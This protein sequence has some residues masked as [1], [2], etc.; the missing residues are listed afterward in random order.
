MRWAGKAAAPT[1]RQAWWN[2]EPVLLRGSYA[3]G[4]SP[5][6]SCVQWRML[7]ALAGMRVQY[8]AP[9]AGGAMAHLSRR[10]IFFIWLLDMGCAGAALPAS[11]S[12]NGT[13]GHAARL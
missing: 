10:A 5:A 4:P 1:R 8:S 11:S 12:C 6:L 3:R 9:A 7:M 13:W 2:S